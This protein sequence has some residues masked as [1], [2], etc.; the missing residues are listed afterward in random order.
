MA[1]VSVL[2]TISSRLQEPLYTQFLMALTRTNSLDQSRPYCLIITNKHL[3][4]CSGQTPRLYKK[5]SQHAKLKSPSCK[6]VKIILQV[7]RLNEAYLI[8]SFIERHFFGQLICTTINSLKLNGIKLSKIVNTWQVSLK[9]TRQ[10][11]EKT[12]QKSGTYLSKFS[13]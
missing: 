6:N 2:P 11:Q 7:K 12:Q 13:I 1:A 10:Q 5:S 3:F 8:P 4:C 9:W